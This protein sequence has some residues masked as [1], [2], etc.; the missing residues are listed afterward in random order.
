M[1]HSGLCFGWKLRYRIEKDNKNI[2]KRLN[3]MCV[4]CVF[5]PVL[6]LKQNIYIVNN[7]WIICHETYAKHTG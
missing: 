5:I 2:K 1:I 6:F 7:E 4:R 3:R